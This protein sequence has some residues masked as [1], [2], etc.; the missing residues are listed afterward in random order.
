MSK[1]YVT[2]KRRKEADEH[3]K[4][5]KTLY[6]IGA[7]HSELKTNRVYGTLDAHEF[8]DIQDCTIYGTVVAHAGVIMRGCVIP[9]NVT[10]TV[11]PGAILC[12]VE[13]FGLDKG[14]DPADIVI[15]QGCF[16][17]GSEIN[18]HQISIRD[19]ST[20]LY[21]NLHGASYVIGEGFQCC[22]SSCK[23]TDVIIGK[24]AVITGMAVSIKNCTIGDNLTI[25]NYNDI[26]YAHETNWAT[27]RQALTGANLKA[28]TLECHAGRLLIGDDFS[29]HT[30]GKIE[31]SFA[32][33]IGNRVTIIQSDSMQS[34]TCLQV[35]KIDASDDSKIAYCSTI[36][37]Y[38]AS[39]RM[40]NTEV[41]LG[42]N[43]TLVVT[44]VLHNSL[45]YG[46]NAII[47]IEDKRTVTV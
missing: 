29:I 12:D 13:F 27:R 16:I 14:S 23:L 3:V 8:S 37:S 2:D 11:M 28:F 43:S 19:G 17:I 31:S 9:N 33:T 10:L 34:N 21:S 42:N 20:V 32:G 40:F 41:K 36:R 4:R 5:F 44:G 1:R 47:E 46:N 22:S 24:Q 6:N 18:G 38:S 39:V 30:I 26:M 45:G 35:R 15:G 25:A 7:E